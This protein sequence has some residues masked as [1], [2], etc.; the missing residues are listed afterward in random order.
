MDAFDFVVAGIPASVQATRSKK[1][2]QAR[3]RRAATARWP[4]GTPP[5]VQELTATIIYFYVGDTSLDVDNIAKPILDALKGIV[6]P[7]DHLITQLVVRK[8]KLIP[9]LAINNPSPEL[10][11][12][13]AQMRGDFVYVRIN[14]APHHSEVP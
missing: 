5:L 6:Y 12:A 13:L 7:D 8:T 14:R 9:G 2:W 4:A 10:A 3:V 11:S 1:P